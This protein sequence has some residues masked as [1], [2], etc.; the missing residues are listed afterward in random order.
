MRKK[1]WYVTI[2]GYAPFPMIPMG[3]AL[4]QEDAQACARV[5]WPMAVVG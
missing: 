1:S 3:E 4:S 5:I 2:P